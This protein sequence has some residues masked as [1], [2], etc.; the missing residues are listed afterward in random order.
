M[1]YMPFY[2]Q[3]RMFITNVHVLLTLIRLV[4]DLVLVV[5]NFGSNISP[6]VLFCRV[7]QNDCKCWNQQ[8]KTVSRSF[9]HPHPA[10]LIDFWPCLRRPAVLAQ[11]CPS[12]TVNLCEFHQSERGRRDSQTNT[13]EAALQRLPVDKK[14]LNCF[15]RSKPVKGNYLHCIFYGKLASRCVFTIWSG[16]FLLCTSACSRDVTFQ[17]NQIGNIEGFRLYFSVKIGI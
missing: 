10:E 3:I 5:I 6:K 2:W 17:W 16:V 1:Q 9:T 8:P 11:S 7:G 13:H 12:V 14:N 15:Y 4:I